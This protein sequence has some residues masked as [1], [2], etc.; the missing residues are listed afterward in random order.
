MHTICPWCDTEIVWDEEIGP[1]HVCPHC[2][3]ELGDYRSL[4]IADAE[5]PDD[6]AGHSDEVDSEGTPLHGIERELEVAKKL[7]QDQQEWLIC[8]ACDE[9]MIHLGTQ[10]LDAP[11]FVP[12]VFQQSPIIQRPVRSEM[13]LCL[14]CNRI[15]QVLSHADRQRWQTFLKS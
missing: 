13:F 2:E 10:T 1:E 9:P 7:L 8:T 14:S 12:R 5:L 4:P 11:S 15:E 3:N 6:D